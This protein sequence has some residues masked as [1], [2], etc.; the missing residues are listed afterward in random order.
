MPRPLLAYPSSPFTSLAVTLPRRL[1][2][3]ANALLGM[4]NIICF[5]FVL[6]LHI[7]G[8]LKKRARL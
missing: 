6:K 1:V 5:F 4:V 3:V 2:A 8:K 7:W